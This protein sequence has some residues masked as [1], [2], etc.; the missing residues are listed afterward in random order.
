LG[1]KKKKEGETSSEG[2]E[3]IKLELRPNTGKGGRGDK[4]N[5]DGFLT[6]A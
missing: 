1:I 3:S 6:P 2:K 5:L 4:E